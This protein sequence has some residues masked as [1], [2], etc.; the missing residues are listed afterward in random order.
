[1]STAHATSESR[2]NC[3]TKFEKLAAVGNVDACDRESR[4]SGNILQNSDEE[5]E[6]LVVTLIDEDSGQRG[7]QPATPSPKT[8]LEPGS[9]DAASVT[10]P[11]P[12]ASASTSRSGDEQS[13]PPIPFDDM[14]IGPGPGISRAEWNRK[15][16]RAALGLPPK[17]PEKTPGVNEDADTINTASAPQEDRHSS[18]DNTSPSLNLTTSEGLN[19]ASTDLNANLAVTFSHEAFVPPRSH[20]PAAST[21]HPGFPASR[22]PSPSDP[23]DRGSPPGPVLRAVDWESRVVPVSLSSDLEVDELDEQDGSEDTLA[24]G[25]GTSFHLGMNP[26]GVVKSAST[27][28]NNRFAY[29]HTPMAGWS[30]GG[31][32]EQI[33]KHGD[34]KVFGM[35]NEVD[36]DGALIQSQAANGTESREKLI[37]RLPARGSKGGDA[38]MVSTGTDV[39]ASASVSASPTPPSPSY[40]MAPSSRKGGADYDRLRELGALFNCL[41][42]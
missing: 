2:P 23:E 30:N 21:P 9:S 38:G 25:N 5:D 27:A 8:H 41:L 37:I 34:G 40:H 22:S 1:M 20:T 11:V 31:M 32:D 6:G 3:D 12:L 10:A 24:I 4:T 29:Q 15:R 26:E 16:F 14:E 42:H 35:G 13:S 33:W 28:Y 18:L 39:S 19:V 36:E 17:V 7:P